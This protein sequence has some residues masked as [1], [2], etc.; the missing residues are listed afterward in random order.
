MPQV[1]VKN[2]VFMVP[3]DFTVR[4]PPTWYSVTGKSNVLWKYRKMRQ[5]KS[6]KLNS[7]VVPDKSGWKHWRRKRDVVQE[8]SKR[9]L[10]PCGVL[11][12]RKR[13][14][15]H[16]KITLIHKITRL[17]TAGQYLMNPFDSIFSGLFNDAQQVP[18]RWP[19]KKFFGKILSIKQLP[20]RDLIWKI[21]VE[22]N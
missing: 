9:F 19:V 4:V 11:W 15:R 22:R 8:C 3:T 17:L 2:T 6:R 5:I 20:V 13:G 21:A 7:S 16:G 14:H 1:S 18:H 10:G 12:F